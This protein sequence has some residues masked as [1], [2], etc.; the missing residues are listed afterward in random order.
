[1]DG[2]AWGVSVASGKGMWGPTLVPSCCWGPHRT[3]TLETYEKDAK[4]VEQCQCRTRVGIGRSGS[5]A[6]AQR[7][8]VGA[9]ADR[10]ALDS[11]LDS[12]E[13]GAGGGGSPRGAVE[14]Y[15]GAVEKEEP[16]AVRSSLVLLP[17]VPTIGG[18]PLLCTP[19]PHFLC[20]GDFWAQ[21]AAG[22][23]PLASARRQTR[24]V[25]TRS[26][27]WTTAVHYHHEPFRRSQ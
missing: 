8:T 6:A 27:H 26:S 9:A 23:Q 25:G 4:L 10:T 7:L 12:G 3:E 5:A 13:S 20:R 22:P 19:S 16:P 17:H 1:M 11:A 14:H 18:A 15:Q 24:R 2:G 21:R